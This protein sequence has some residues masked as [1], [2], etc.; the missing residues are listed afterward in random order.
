MVSLLTPGSADGSQRW[1]RSSIC[2]TNACVEV[3][4]RS[5]GYV[6]VRDSKDLQREPLVFT[7][8]EFE[9]WVAGAKAGDFDDLC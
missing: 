6:E 7:V 4:Y 5:D 8:E 9:A 3:A 1:R 2:A